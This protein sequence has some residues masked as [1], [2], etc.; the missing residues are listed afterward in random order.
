MTDSGSLADK[1]ILITGAARGMGAVEARMATAQ[2]AT[3][4]AADV[5]DDLGNEVSADTGATYHHLDVTS[6]ADWNAVVSSIIETH[7]R[8]D[9]LVNNAGAWRA[10]TLLDGD[11]DTY[12]IVVS[13]NQD[14]VYNGMAAVAPHMRDQNFGSIVNI[15]SVAGFKGH[16]SVAYTAAKWAVRGMTKS[17]AAELGG[18]NVRVNSVHPGAVETDMLVQL[19]Q[20]NRDRL[21]SRIPMERVA[22]ADEVANVVMFLLSDD[23]SYV[24]G[25]EI[26][27]DGAYLTR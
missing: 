26:V 1:V 2:G 14:G 11:E 6:V 20:E 23:S 8:I 17:T 9:G 15:S 18:F 16:R 3:V 27:V 25:T 12:R 4:I 5:L 21:V 22:T 13:V 19:G 24:S 7:G 10:H